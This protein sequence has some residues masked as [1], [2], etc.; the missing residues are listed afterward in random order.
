MQGNG[1][2]ALDEFDAPAAR[3]EQPLTMDLVIDPPI[4]GSNG[5]TYEHLHLEEPTARMVER[6]EAELAGNFN[7]HSLRKY[8]IA[9][10]SHATGTPR[11][12]IER[13]R[14]SQLTKASDFLSTF[15]G[16]GR[17]IGAS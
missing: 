5:K 8:Q 15:I 11:D 2:L 14:I 1:N 6:A 10:V 7:V 16:S 17:A 13:M 3:S 12:V 4:E 9:L